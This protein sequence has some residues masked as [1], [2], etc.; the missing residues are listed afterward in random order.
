MMLKI[1]TRSTQCMNHTSGACKNATLRSDPFIQQANQSHSATNRLGIASPVAEQMDPDRPTNQPKAGY[2]G[3]A[4][5]RGC[6][7][8]D[9]SNARSPTC[10]CTSVDE[11]QLYTL[12]IGK[13]INVVLQGAAGTNC[14][15]IGIDRVR[16]FS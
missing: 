11:L 1:F 15:K 13:R 12:P 4:P 16:M 7:L 10:V 14:D 9:R 3:T 2:T 6:R 5:E 8:D